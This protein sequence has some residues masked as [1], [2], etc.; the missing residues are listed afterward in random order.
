MNIADC[1]RIVLFNYNEEKDEVEFR[2]YSIMCK[3]VG[4]SRSVRRIIEVRE[5]LSAVH[6]TK[7]GPLTPLFVGISGF[8]ADKNPRFEP[9]GGH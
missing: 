9:T 2:H 7:R 5:H 1:R 6:P 8:Y 4:I 3:P